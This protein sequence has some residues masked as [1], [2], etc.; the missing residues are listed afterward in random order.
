M[1]FEINNNHVKYRQI[2]KF[3]SEFKG[4]TPDNLFLRIIGDGFKYEIDLFENEYYN[5][6]NL[7][8]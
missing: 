1:K 8:W 5:N 2:L 6:S 7:E 4:W 3:H